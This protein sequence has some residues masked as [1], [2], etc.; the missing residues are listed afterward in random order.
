MSHTPLDRITYEVI[1]NGLYAIA[2]EMKVAMMRTSASPIIHSGGD[3]SAAIFDAQMQLVAQG[4]DIPTML[5]SSVLSTKASVESVGRENLRPGDVIVSND[6]Y[7]AGGNHQPDVQFTRPVFVDGEIVAFTM[8]RGHWMDIGGAYPGAFSA[9]THDIFGEGLRIPPVLLF[10]DEKPVPD[11]LKLLLTNSRAPDNMRLDIQAMYAGTIVGDRRVAELVK[12]YGKESLAQT[13]V[14]SLDY[15]ES[16]MRAHLAKIPDGVYEAEDSIEP[17]TG[18]GGNEEPIPI[19]VKIT[20]KGDKIAFDYTGSAL[21]VRG[22]VN[23][24]LAVTCN[25]T[26]Y[27]VKAITSAEIPA[28]QGCYRPVEV[29][30]PAGSIL[31][32]SYPASVFSG[33]T[34]SAQRVVDLLLR[35]LAPA[36]P[37]RVIAQS[38]GGVSASYIAGEDPDAQ[39]CRKLGRS[40]VAFTDIHAGGMG[41]RPEADGVNA[42]RVH[43]GN[44]GSQSVE[45]VERY[46]PVR[47]LDWS[48]IQDSGGA[49]RTRG[50]LGCTR[51]YEILYDEASF[52]VMSERGQVAPTGLF[53]GGEGSKYHCVVEHA[54][55]RRSQV[56]AKAAPVQVRKGDRIYY[57][58]AGSGGYGSPA[59]RPAAEVAEDVLNEYISSDAAKHLYGV[60]I[61][62]ADGAV[63]EAATRVERH[64]LESRP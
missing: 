43:T 25:A 2:R 54:D 22:G 41:A 31:N 37:K 52:S 55:G 49:G 50:G 64:R 18:I 5:G 53:G 9:V 51:T 30:A 29:I 36:I 6:A 20:V 8:T 62:T 46:H 19:R 45:L 56:P 26:W 12:R 59:L 35:A 21:Q 60:V 24:T 13:M 4:N 57:H 11:V 32:C 38:H 61:S 16:L 17:V 58:A 28:N 63:D 15:S 23:C 14:Q 27:V 3:A 33:N 44:A 10:R 39:R 42:L 34:D 1:R 47:V 40:Y 48:L 7:L